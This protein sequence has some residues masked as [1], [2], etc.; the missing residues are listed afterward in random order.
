MFKGIF[1]QHTILGFNK[2]ALM[3]FVSTAI[4]TGFFWLGGRRRA[5]VPTGVQNAAE[6]SYEM[7]EEQISLA[8]IGEDGRNWTPFF[9]TLFFLI[10]FINIFEVV[11]GVEFPATSRFAIPLFLALMSW[12][13]FIITGFV[14]QGP[15]YFWHNIMP[16]RRPRSRCKFLV[17]PIELFSK[18]LV[19]PFSLRGAALRQ[20]DRRPR[21]AGDLRDA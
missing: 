15:K 17:V 9:A 2:T 3:A 10:F 12:A 21:P 16:A 8:A 4:C 14:K 20:H 19:R 1:A 6:Y 7:I 13:I 5:L 18:Y 11:P